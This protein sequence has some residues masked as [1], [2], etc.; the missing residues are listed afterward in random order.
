MAF[1]PKS[2]SLSS[3]VQSLKDERTSKNTVSEENLRERRYFWTARAF[4]MVFATSLITNIIMLMSLF[5]LVSLVRVQPYELTFSDK[6]A[7]T[8]TVQPFRVDDRLLNSISASMVRQYVTLRKTITPDS[9]E[10]AYR[11]GTNGPID[12]LSTP[13]TFQV[14]ANQ[15]GKIL[16][17]AVKSQVTR[18]VV[19]KSAIPYVSEGKGKGEYWIVDYDLI[20]MSPQNATEEIVPYVAT[21]YVTYE[22]YDNRWE[23]RLKNPIG[24]K[25][26]QFG[27]ETRESYDMREREK[28]KNNR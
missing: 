27:D 3:K 22:P 5:S 12:L 20:T 28:V 7:Q 26:A 10:M 23:N 2:A 17:A 14:F 9:D 16:D 11:W 21:V 19:I 1:F 18:N 25:V 6:N 24:F 13:N 15:A 4:A 8:V